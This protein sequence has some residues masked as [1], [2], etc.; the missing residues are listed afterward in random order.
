ML[1]ISNMVPTLVFID[2]GYLS[3][4]C[5][6]FGRG[7]Y[8]KLDIAQFAEHLAEKQGMYCQHMFYYTAPPFQSGKPTR[9][10]ARM[11]A[12]Y[13]SFISHLTKRDNVTVRE[14]RLQKIGNIFTQKGVDTL[15]TLDLAFE[16]LARRINCILLVACDTD[17][18][19]A[20]T[21]IRDN[22]IKVIIYYFSDRKRKS[23]F[24]MSNHILT[25]CDKGILL[26]EQD[27]TKNVF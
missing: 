6:H 15:L 24:S 18:V 3:K 7:R 2:G 8:L 1:Y 16:P 12:G 20:L 17:F 21:R 11:K 9:L 25:A 10:E 23:I 27:F 26:E 5:K 4:L 22:G 19:P 14:G 13:D